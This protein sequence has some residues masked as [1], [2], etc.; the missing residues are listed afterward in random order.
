MSKKKRPK[1]IKKP[2]TWRFVFEC[3]ECRQ[4]AMADLDARHIPY[5]LEGVEIVSGDRRAYNLFQANCGIFE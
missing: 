2:F 1:R 3:P 4:Q 5:T